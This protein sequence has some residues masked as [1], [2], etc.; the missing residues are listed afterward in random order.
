[1]RILM[2]VSEIALIINA[3]SMLMMGVSTYLLRKQIT[4]EHLWNR[5]KVAEE[6]LT[7]FTNGQFLACLD[8]L[9]EQY[10]W[11]VLY[12]EGEKYQQVIE[13]L[14]VDS[15][16]RKALDRQLVTI[17]RH[18]ESIAIKMNHGILDEAIAHD[19]LFSVLTN[20]DKKCKG[21]LSKIREER[22]ETCVYKNAE[23]F[24]DKW[25]QDCAS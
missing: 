12:K 10:H 19:Y 18:L 8:Q 3:I 7:I 15:E 24:A 4:A 1:M 2:T 21:F 11:Q 22:N 16:E 9:S 6:T 13:R 25:G 20:I 23:F 17:Y 5:R 14:G